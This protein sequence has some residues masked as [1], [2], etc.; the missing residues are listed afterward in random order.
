MK[1]SVDFA[2]VLLMFR[3]NEPRPKPIGPD[4]GR[5]ILLDSTVVFL[6]VLVL[7]VCFGGV[8]M[9]HVGDFSLVLLLFRERRFCST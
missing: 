9:E 5:S 8:L 1:H 4:C 7:G 3:A 2:L 6:I